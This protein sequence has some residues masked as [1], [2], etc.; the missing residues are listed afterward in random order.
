MKINILA[1]LR[2]FEVKLNISFATKLRRKEALTVLCVICYTYDF[3]F[4][5]HL[6]SLSNSKSHMILN[7]FTPSASRV[8]LDKLNKIR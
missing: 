5:N 2:D 6:V 3:P 4:N 7:A 8:K 1:R